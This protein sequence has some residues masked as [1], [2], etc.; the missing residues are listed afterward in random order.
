MFSPN[1]TPQDI[2]QARIFEEPL[3][4]IGADPPPAENAALA[5]ALLGY[6]KR[7]GPD[8]FSSLTGFLRAYPTSPWNA[9]LLTDLGLEYYNTGH[10]SKALE[11]WR[12][13]WELAKGATDPRGKA[14]AE[15]AVGELAYIYAR[16]GQMAELDVLLKSVEG[17]V[18]S[19]PATE[20]IT[21]AR[22]GLW[23]M[24]NR[25][26]IAFR[27]GP[28]ALH[29]I[30]LSVHPQNPG[31]DLIHAAASTQQGFSL[32]QVAELSH[33]LG[34]YFQMAFR[35]KGAAFVVP[36]VVH[37]KV[38]H[39][40][41][42]VRQEGDRYLLQDP[43]F[44]NDTWATREALEAETSGY[45]LIPSGELPRGWRAVHAQ[46]GEAVWGKG[47]VGGPDP[48]PHGPCDPSSGGGDQCPQPDPACNGMARPRVHLLL[49]SLNINDEPVGYSPPVG[50]AVRF[51]VRYNQRD[52][53]QPSNFA[54]SNL[55]PKWTFDWLS[56]IT[57]NPSSPSA[58]V[59]YYIM[60]GGT[61]TFT[62][63]DNSTQTY[64][65]QQYDQTKLTRTSPDTYEM[66]SR[67]G[68]RKVF[69]RSD[70]STGTSRKV[71]LTQLIDPAGNAVALTYDNDLRVV[72]ITDAIGQFTTL[73]YEHPTDTFKI[74]KIT[75]PFGR[76]ATFDYDASG[77]LI[78]ITDVIGITSEFLYDS[79]DFITTLTTPYGVTT[80]TKTENGTTRALET[81]YPDGERDRVEFNQSTN[82]PASDPPQSVP[83]GVATR[84]E[85]LVF[86]NTFYWDKQACAFAYGD[87]T[88]ARLYHWLHTT[89]IHV[90]SGI[91]ESTKEPLEGRVWFDYAGQ[92]NDAIGRITVG[93]T[94]KPAHV[95][96]VL[97]DGSTRLYT[98]E[99]N[100]FG[101]VTKTIDPV[102]RTFSFIYADN[103]IDLL[104]IRQTRA[105]QNELLSQMTYNAQ[106]LPLTFKDAA[107]QMTVYTYNA[108]GQLLT[109]T[110]AKNETTTY[111]YDSNGYLTSV[112]GPLP[113]TDDIISL[114]YDSFGRLRTKTHESGYI[115]TFDYDA[116]DRLTKVTYPDSTF[117]EFAYT[118]LDCTLMRD[119]AGRQTSFEY[120][121]VR[122]MVKRTDPLNRITLFQWCKCGALKALVD[123]MGRAT[124]WRHDVQGRIKSKEYADGSKVVYLYETTTSRLRQ[125]IDGK[126]QVIQYTYNLDNTLRAVNYANAA[127]V[128]PAVSFT[129]DPNYRRIT[130]MTDGTGTTEYAYIHIT[131]F[132][133][134][135]AGQLGSENGPG[136]D[137]TVTYGYDELGRRITT[138][139][140]GVVSTLTLDAATRVTSVTNVLGTFNYVYDG[141]S[142]RK[143]SQS[144]SNG[145]TTEFQYGNISQ[146]KLLQRITN[147]AGGVVTSDNLSEFIYSHNVPTGQIATWSQRA[148][149]QTP[150]IYS[151]GC[152]AANQLT[153]ATVSQGGSVL[154]TFNYGYDA[155]SN[156][157]SE[158]I[159][160]ATT[161]FFCN[162]LNELTSSDSKG[163]D[164]ASYEWDAE[165]RLV[166]L[167][168][169]NKSV[170]FTYDGLGRCVGIRQLV[171]GSEISYRRFTWCGSDIC[172]ERTLDGTVSKRFFEQ[173]M[174]LENGPTTGVFFYTRD[175]LGSV[176]EIT[177]STA[178]V[179]ARY[180]YDPFGRRIRSQGDMDADFGFAGMFFAAEVGFSLTWFRIYDPEVGRWL[181]RDPL[182]G[183]EL[184]QGHN[185]YKYA[186]NDPVNIRDLSGLQ[187][188]GGMASGGVGGMFGPLAPVLC[189]WNV[190]SGPQKVG[191]LA[192]K[193]GTVAD[194]YEASQ[195][196]S[197]GIG[198]ILDCA[199]C[200]TGIATSCMACISGLIPP[201]AP[202]TDCEDP[203]H[204]PGIHPG[205]RPSPCNPE[206]ICPEPSPEP[207]PVCS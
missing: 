22:E 19:G 174:R 33:K 67:D 16:L 151:F 82:I 57:D 143:L 135:G 76:F 54:Y 182:K 62:G 185:L 125:K 77:R 170:R 186:L 60:G 142:E 8:D 200:A 160:S 63:F 110:N 59:R 171:A 112:D 137:H 128:T 81:V 176:R 14:L 106:H 11:A 158:Q 116:L 148:G 91:L 74:T 87:Y 92:S 204:D 6:S 55:G 134:L 73:S 201:P 12:Q 129:Y 44:G 24:H 4:P 180:A 131:P 47:N 72:R 150:A 20:R 89:D 195:G 32:Q 90:A 30:K 101:N 155:A 167:T 194:A 126:L 100:G 133:T 66:L 96:R 157:S 115:L 103:S 172:E 202:L 39:Y 31:T 13:A 153:S 64:A 9:A 17:R 122:Q 121:S 35:E 132:P 123:P 141:G 184:S 83:G 199:S 205:G 198:T 163:G 15:R 21:G 25:P 192:A 42:M 69:N 109:K 197:G 105:G 108:R 189:E 86:R 34:L 183:A 99:Y 181:S 113:G 138:A 50:P 80:F 52:A 178:V 53:F 152:D 166:G 161:H 127:V 120:N 70:G 114:T 56:Y 154:N 169:G 149:T 58:D 84:N 147:R 156:R 75:D 159:D 95:G 2:F 88:K 117:D 119:R 7:S 140:N 130:S 78:K 93:N 124:K 29:R 104:E 168:S 23:N 165:Q 85:F 139:I 193:A 164:P 28:L 203:G 61:R 79:G 98:Y 136:P 146:D 190:L 5:A 26:E 162:A 145:Q 191:F 175:H 41:A 196:D 187:G 49:V 107:G 48:G 97:D 18:F 179:R 43:T 207:G 1:P 68:T 10:Y 102:G 173:G 144:Y 206:P 71:F 177:D 45:F 3:V 37:L 40:A 65:F 38:D 118:G 36:S 51:M 46:E 111:H 188:L 27:C 94:N